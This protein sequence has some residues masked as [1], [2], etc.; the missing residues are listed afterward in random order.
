MAQTRQLM[1]LQAMSRNC[2]NFAL[3]TYATIVLDPQHLSFSSD[4]ISS[5]P[6]RATLSPSA[7]ATLRNAP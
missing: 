1:H 2:K 5:Q 3:E 6:A 4:S 7:R